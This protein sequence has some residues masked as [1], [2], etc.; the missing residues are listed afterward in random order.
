MIKKR[1]NFIVGSFFLTILFLFFFVDLKNS[2]KDR[3][4]LKASFNK[5]DGILVGSDVRLSG[6]KVGKVINLEL[7]KNKPTIQVSLNKDIILP[8]DSSISIQTDGLFGN[9]YLSIEPGGSLDYFKNNE[10][11]QFTED[12]ILLEDLLNKI[13]QIGNIKKKWEQ[14]M[15][16]SY[17]ETIIGTII[18]FFSIIFLFVFFRSNSSDYISESYKL[19]AQFLKVGGIVVGNDVKL[20]GVKIGTVSDVSLNNDYFAVIEFYINNKIKIPENSTIM[21]NSEGILGN[22]YLSI[23]PGDKD[24]LKLKPNHEIKNVMDYESIEDQV[25]KIIFLATQ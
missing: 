24:N 10:K 20:S 5:I 3:L 13:I 4:L 8:N 23:I 17:F 12:S 22:K 21:V 14:F 6:I 16:K 1:E 7:D 2:D 25:S 19:K 11:I 9:K 15:K 18:I